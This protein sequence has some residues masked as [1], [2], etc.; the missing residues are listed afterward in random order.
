MTIPNVK[1]LVD[2]ANNCKAGTIISS[3]LGTSFFSGG[4]QMVI[5]SKVYLNSHEGVPARVVTG[6]SFPDPWTLTL[7]LTTRRLGCLLDFGQGMKSE[8]DEN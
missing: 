2:L 1:V 4:R 8:K 5:H 3:G 7:T 6:T